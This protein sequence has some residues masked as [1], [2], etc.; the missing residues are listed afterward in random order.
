M[1]KPKS[2]TQSVK[3]KLEN[4]FMHFYT[5]WRITSNSFLLLF[6]SDF[7]YLHTFLC[8]L[9]NKPQVMRWYINH[10]WCMVHG[11]WCMVHGAW[12]IGWIWMEWK[13]VQERTVIYIQFQHVA[14]II[15]NQL[16]SSQTPA[17]QQ[18]ESRCWN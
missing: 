11:A 15:I 18:Y 7:L 1:V 9:F 6:V 17:G 14:T 2:G 3:L 5:W 8:K 4:V 16:W 12:G 13:E 10:A